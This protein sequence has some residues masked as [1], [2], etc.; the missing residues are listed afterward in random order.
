MRLLVIVGDF[1]GVWGCFR[2]VG[3]VEVRLVKFWGIWG[4]VRGRKFAGFEGWWVGVFLGNIVFLVLGCNGEVRLVVG[5]K[6]FCFGWFV[7]G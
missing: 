1:F 5:G 3:L 2:V 6:G 4:E 7:L